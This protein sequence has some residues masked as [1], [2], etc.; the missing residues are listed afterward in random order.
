MTGP[1][2]PTISVIMAVYNGAPYLAQT[3]ESVLQQSYHNFEFIIVDDGSTDTTPHILQD[4]AALDA[5]ICLLPTD[6]CR[7][8]FCR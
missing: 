3:I 1:A 8:S 6:R 5:R 2:V 4:Y 7:R